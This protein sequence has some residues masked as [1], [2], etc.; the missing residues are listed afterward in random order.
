MA[1]TLVQ[2]QLESNN[3]VSSALA[4]P[5]R[6]Q[7]E[8]ASETA[9]RFETLLATLSMTLINTPIREIDRTI[10]RGL[11]GVV[12]ECAL[13]CGTLAELVGEVTTLRVKYWYGLPGTPGSPTDHFPLRHSFSCV[14]AHG[15][16]IWAIPNPDQG[17]MVCFTLPASNEVTV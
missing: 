5:Q 15:G 16:R 9:M 11:Q 17:G 4:F 8:T 14:E 1:I 3:A 10:E 6:Q 13:E 12:E 2:L 7:G